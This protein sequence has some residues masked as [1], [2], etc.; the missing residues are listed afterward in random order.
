VLLYFVC[1]D[2]AAFSQEQAQVWQVFLQRDVDTSGTDQ[3]LFMDVLTGDEVE[4]EVS[5]ERYSIVEQAVMYFDVTTRRVMLASADG[6]TRPHPSI[7]P[8]L[9]TRRVDWIVSED[10]SAIAWTLTEGEP[11]ALTTITTVANID[12]TNPHPVLQ[13]GPRNGIRAMPVA[14]NGDNTLLYMDYQPDVIG[15]FT[16]FRQYAGLFS[17]DVKDST[18]AY[19]PGE[20]G[21]FCGAGIGEGWFLRLALTNDLS[22][23]DVKV[24]NLTTQAEF[25]I[26]ALRLSNYTQAG[27]IVVSSDGTRAVYALA[28]IRDFGQPTQSTETVFMLVNLLDLTQTTLTQ[29]VQTFVRPMAFTDDN[30]AVLFTSPEED[31]TWKV[32][33][34]DGRLTKVAD[35]TYLGTLG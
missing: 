12:G 6:T 22:G 7:Q 31:G 14:F 28:Q 16:P 23:F 33:I 4:I 2:T 8:G 10:G 26:P 30:T 11:A 19:L 9:L 32:N 5:G 1:L 13:D 34:G 21:C 20:P 3:L 18:V 25:V 15:D 29:P 24:A 17:V 27:G 35:A